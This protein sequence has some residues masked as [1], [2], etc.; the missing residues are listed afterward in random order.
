M[1]TIC[2]YVSEG[3]RSYGN[4]GRNRFGGRERRCL[5]HDGWKLEDCRNRIGT[6]LLESDEP[7]R[8]RAT[9]TEGAGPLYLGPH[10]C[11]GSRRSTPSMLLVVS[12]PGTES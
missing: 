5:F 1:M 12:Q 9:E 8:A 2:A 3:V 10:G 4:S 11:E 7:E 6:V